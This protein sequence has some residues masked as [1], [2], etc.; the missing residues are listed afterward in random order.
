MSH[1]NTNEENVSNTDTSP[2]ETDLSDSRPPAIPQVNHDWFARLTDYFFSSL[3]SYID[4]DTNPYLTDI[5][6]ENRPRF[7]PKI[8]GAL[9]ISILGIA[10][11][12]ALSSDNL[13]L[14]PIQHLLPRN[15]D[16]NGGTAYWFYS[17]GVPLC[18]VLFAF[19]LVYYWQYTK[20]LAVFDVRVTQ[21]REFHV[22]SA[23]RWMIYVP[24]FVL[25]FV[26]AFSPV[27]GYW[28]FFVCGAVFLLSSICTLSVSKKV[29]RT[30]FDIQSWLTLQDGA[31]LR[32]DR[33]RHIAESGALDLVYRRWIWTN[34]FTAT[35]I[36][37]Y[38]IV[39]KYLELD[40]LY[41]TGYVFVLVFLSQMVSVVRST[42]E[43]S[44]R[45]Y[46]NSVEIVNRE[47]QNH[48]DE[49]DDYGVNAEQILRNL[50]TYYLVR[51][52]TI[53]KHTLSA[54][55]GSRQTS[56]L[57]ALAETSRL[58]KSLLFSLVMYL[59]GMEPA[60]AM[61]VFLGLAFTY[62]FND[63]V[64]FL[65]GKDDICHPNR[66]LPSGRIGLR[67]A[68]WY[69]LLLFASS[70]TGA[71]VLEVQSIMPLYAL[72]FGGVLYSAFFKYRLPVLAT[73]FWCLLVALLIQEAMEAS[74]AM[75]I[76]IWFIVMARELLLDL[77]DAESDFVVFGKRNLA[78]ALGGLHWVFS[79]LLFTLAGLIFSVE[80]GMLVGGLSIAIGVLLV[81]LA[82]RDSERIG[83]SAALARFSF[84][85]HLAWPVVLLSG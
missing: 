57:L 15:I 2:M 29:R 50:G 33:I 43:Y 16:E 44:D 40:T 38:P 75:L 17:K 71:L 83:R 78:L 74:S 61:L 19:S 58:V 69:V 10:I 25:I 81:V 84:L 82:A 45:R 5:R 39:L 13:D 77:R 6:K 70:V 67:S 85:S 66:P 79:I 3:V 8:F 7:F 35:F 76:G 72:I 80:I 41:S 64:D 37:T 9:S 28:S 4:R 68:A 54:S 56:P 21:M 73:P 59:L 49:D 26:I 1:E 12:I 34:V 20:Y 31:A 63:F 62:S 48:S 24:Q 52:P 18:F 36:S 22:A 46:F 30:L 55:Y 51:D 23:I 65:S 53:E 32:L 27:L 14:G 60:L 47:I 11:A 42:G